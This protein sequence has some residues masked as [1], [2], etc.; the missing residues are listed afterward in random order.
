MFVAV[1]SACAASTSLPDSLLT[2][3]CVYKYTF[4][5]FDRAQQIMDELRKKQRG[6]EYK[7]N[8]AEGDL[9]FNTGHYYQALRFYGRALDSKPVQIDAKQ[10]MELF[11][12]MISCYDCVHNETKKAQYV[13][14]LLKKAEACGDEA[15]QSVALFNMGKMLYY[16]GNKDKGYQY[17]QQ[18][19]EQMRGTDYQYKYD[20]LR[21][22]YNTLLVF[23]EL[24][25]RCEEALRT[26]DA[27]E[28]V[29]TDNAADVAEMDGI[30]EKARKA[31]IAHRA[32]ISYRL[33]RKA[34]ADNYYRQFLAMGGATDRDNYLIMPYL[35]DRGLYDEVIRMNAT[36]EKMLSE[37]GDTVNYHMTTI[38]KSLGHAYLE[39]GDYKTAAHYY[40]QLAVLR[41]SIKNR[42][43]K[44]V[45]LELAAVY[46][47]N[48]KEMN[49]PPRSGCAP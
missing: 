24:D 25:N 35:F 39:K 40:K 16:E 17:M 23:Q 45:A 41:D 49:R 28:K 15:M 20:N 2:V 30:D 11:H 19:A 27:L 36:R 21:Y 6:P 12:R 38:K 3:D 5:D 48:E 1:T 37:L 32:V 13:A 8:I 7:L 42:E 4:S 9:Y 10:Q 22:D 33:E 47:T 43:Q 18:A 31:M 44:S 29:V 14:M 26:L 46:E 34:E